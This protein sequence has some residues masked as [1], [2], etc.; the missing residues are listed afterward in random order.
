MC[1]HRATLSRRS[2]TPI[3]CAKGRA[4]GIRD[5]NIPVIYSGR[6]H[7]RAK[8]NGATAA[9]RDPGPE[10]SGN[11]LWEQPAARQKR[12]RNGNGAA[13]AQRQLRWRNCACAAYAAPAL[14]VGAVG[15]AIS[16]PPPSKH[17]APPCSVAPHHRR[18]LGRSRDRARRSRAAVM[19]LQPVLLPPVPMARQ[20]PPPPSERRTATLPHARH[21]PTPRATTA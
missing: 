10:Y 9:A 17:R 21:C 15:W 11:L 1:L 12:R 19:P 14:S 7:R 18:S 5:L 6:N 3:A 20:Q 8:R 2:L 16:P 4:R 13:T